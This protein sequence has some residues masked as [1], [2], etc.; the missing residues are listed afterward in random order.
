M[1]L[2]WIADGIW[3]TARPQKFWGV[4]TG[5]RTT[6][7]R[8]SP[9]PSDPSSRGGL[10]VHCPVSLD[11]ELKR[12]VDA[13]GPVVAV[14]AS[15]LYHHLYVG[16][17]M[18]AYP[19]ALFAACPGLPEKRKDLAFGHVLGDAPH[20]LWKDDLEPLW[21]SAR[22]EKEVVFF[23]RKARTLI[24]ADALLNLRHHRSRRTRLVAMLMG[25]LGPGWGWMERIAVQ[26]W[27]LGRAQVDRMLDWDIERIVLAH[28]DLVLHHGREVLREAYAW[29]PA[30]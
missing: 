18:R 9:D 17:W 29:L 28:G 3:T 16:E 23:H 20:P 5:T 14:A 22:F 19:N 30:A 21:L 4:E 11:P 26:D 15:S 6:I 13:L 8:L 1:T 10:F 25:N 24:C 2:E 7:V 27:K 12:E